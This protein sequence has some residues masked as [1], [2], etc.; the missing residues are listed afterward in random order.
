MASL[1][2]PVYRMQMKKTS[3]PFMSNHRENWNPAWWYAWHEGRSQ[4]S[5]RD[6]RPRG[7]DRGLDWVGYVEL[8]QPSCKRRSSSQVTVWISVTTV[9]YKNIIR[10]LAGSCQTR[11]RPL[12]TAAPGW[13]HTQPGSPQAM[14]VEKALPLWQIAEGSACREVKFGILA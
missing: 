10:F 5:V 13:R 12:L 7:P 2:Y 9:T 8:T 4:K 14:S 3:D 1:C 11:W 6:S